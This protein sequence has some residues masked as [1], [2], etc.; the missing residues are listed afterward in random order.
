MIETKEDL[1]LSFALLSFCRATG[2]HD[3]GVHA[4]PSYLHTVNPAASL[5]VSS[6]RA[7]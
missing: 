7:T 3:P 2:I 4:P 6:C 1:P 5:F